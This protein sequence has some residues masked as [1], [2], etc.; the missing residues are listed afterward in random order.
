MAVVGVKVSAGGLDGGVAEEVLEDVERDASVSHPGRAGVPE[1]V[2]GEV[3][4]AEIADD[5]V[6]V[7]RV[8]HGRGLETTALRADQQA[9]LGL[10]PLCEPLKSRAERVEDRDA[11]FSAA[12]GSLRDE[13]AFAGI[14]LPGDDHDVLNEP[15]VTGLEARDLGGSRCEEGGEHDEVGVRLVSFPAGFSEL[16]Q[17]CHVGDRMRARA[18]ILRRLET[19][20]IAVQ[21][22]LGTVLCGVDRHE[23]VANCFIEDPHERGDEVLDR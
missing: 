12:F 3:G 9:V 5:L 19:E 16:R 8:P 23:P 14:G 1:A 6:P 21:A 4:Q 7:R 10:F 17:C 13:P 18:S 11:A 15:N 20:G 22:A 2:L